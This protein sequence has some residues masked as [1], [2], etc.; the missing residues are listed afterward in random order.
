MEAASKIPGRPGR[1][2]IEGY[3]RD[4]YAALWPDL[5]IERARQNRFYAVR[6]MDAFGIVTALKP[7]TME[8]EF[9]WIY[10]EPTAVGAKWEVLSALGRPAGEYLTLQQH[11]DRLRGDSE[12]KNILVLMEA[13]L[14]GAIRDL[15]RSRGARS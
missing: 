13:A 12:H 10:P 3:G 8:H 11:A 6:A 2:R 5:T 14:I 15:G 9:A 4:R 7:G 1:P